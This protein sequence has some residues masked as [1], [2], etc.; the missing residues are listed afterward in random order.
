MP[1]ESVTEE[2]IAELRAG[3]SREAERV[4]AAPD[5]PETQKR[6]IAGTHPYLTALAR[7]DEGWTRAEIGQEL[8]MRMMLG[9]IT[10]KILGSEKRD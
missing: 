8:S 7:V 2:F 9:G 1:H 3:F 6:T 5:W 4:K 10:T